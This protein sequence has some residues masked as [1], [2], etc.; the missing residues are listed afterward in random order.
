M[1]AELRKR[2]SYCCPTYRV[3]DPFS[4]LGA[5]SSF[6]IGDPVFHLIDD[7]EHPLLYLPGTGIA[8]FETAITESLQQNL[9]GIVLTSTPTAH[10]SSFICT[11]RWPSRPSLGREAPW[12]C[13]LYTS[14]YRGMPGP[15]SGSGGVG[16]QG[17]G[18][19]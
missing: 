7:C 11:R 6:S 15:R 13:K 2:F 3:A 4:S 10:I 12:Y 18:R 14:Q 19:V 17:R 16:E 9:S 8:S 5:F 1:D